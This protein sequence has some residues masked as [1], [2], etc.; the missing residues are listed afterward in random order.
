M[1]K[2]W[3]SCRSGHAAVGGGVQLQERGCTEAV[4][5]LQ[6]QRG[7]R[8]VQGVKVQRGAGAEDVGE[9]GGLGAFEPKDTNSRRGLSTVLFLIHCK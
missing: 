2:A 4:G 3:C 6:M 9:C 1:K 8:Q 7:T 5:I